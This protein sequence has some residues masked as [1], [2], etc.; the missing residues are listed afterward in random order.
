MEKVFSNLKEIEVELITLLYSLVID[1]YFWSKDYNSGIERLLEMKREG[2]ELD[3]RIWICFVRAASF[4][5]D[6][7]EVMLLLKVF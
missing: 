6:K 5:K 1:V 3:Y 4:F 7:N 2:L